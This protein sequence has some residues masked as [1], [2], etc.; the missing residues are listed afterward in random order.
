MGTETVGMMM[1]TI[2]RVPFTPRQRECLVFKCQG[3]SSR[4]IADRLF[5]QHQTVK[6]HLTA[7]Y[8]RMG[9]GPDDRAH[10]GFPSAL[11]CYRLGF[12]DGHAAAERTG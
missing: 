7:A 9:L 5:L 12:A 1:A 4:E 10:A 11:A 3:L 6:N 8:E 2:V